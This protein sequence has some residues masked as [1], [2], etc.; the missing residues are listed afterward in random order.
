MS[1][2]K[3][4]AETIVA[5][6]IK[7]E[8]EWNNGEVEELNFPEYLTQYVDDYLTRLEEIKAEEEEDE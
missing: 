1:N 5:W 8:V 7:I 2:I 3:Q 6:Q 4:K